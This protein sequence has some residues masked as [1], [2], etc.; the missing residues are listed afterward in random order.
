VYSSNACMHACMHGLKW[1]TS[2]IPFFDRLS[3]L[4]ADQLK[5]VT[6]GVYGENVKIAFL[7][8]CMHL[9]D[10]TTLPFVGL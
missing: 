6:C 3:I 8:A 10:A 4:T 5:G 1:F 2:V 7:P 9:H